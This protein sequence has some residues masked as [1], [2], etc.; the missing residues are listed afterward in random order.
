[1]GVACGVELP[2][3]GFGVVLPPGLRIKEVG[4]AGAALE[5]VMEELVRA[6]VAA[7]EESGLGVSCCN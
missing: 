2:L 1:M 5:A 6:G 3:F 7:G 4:V